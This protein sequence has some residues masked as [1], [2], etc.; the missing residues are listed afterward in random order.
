MDIRIIRPEQ[1][2]TTA[3]SGGVTREILIFPPDAEY[4]RRDFLYRAS[5]AVVESRESIFTDLPGYDRFI[6]PLSGEVTLSVDRVRHHLLPFE[7]FAFDG[8]ASTTS[9]SGPNLRDLNLM[10]RKGYSAQVRVTRFQEPLEQDVESD[11]LF[12]R[13]RLNEDGT[14]HDIIDAVYKPLGRVLSTPLLEKNQLAVTLTLPQELDE[15]DET[16]L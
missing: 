16:A 9:L 10:V 12:V 5:T 8:A 13:I 1:F 15:P 11:Q 14:F 2:K 4:G 6:L 7:V 3:W